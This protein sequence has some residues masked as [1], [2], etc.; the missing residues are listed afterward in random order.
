[1]MLHE[2]ACRTGEEFPATRTT[3][4]DVARVH[5]CHAGHLVRSGDELPS[6]PQNPRATRGRY[7]DPGHTHRKLR[8]RSPRYLS[9]NLAW[10]AHLSTMR[11]PS[12]A[13]PFTAS[14]SLS[15]FACAG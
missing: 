6:G 14:S 11:L 13:K 12:K 15:V 9:P 10:K 7:A 2:N 4:P 8:D 5:T 1:M 3:S